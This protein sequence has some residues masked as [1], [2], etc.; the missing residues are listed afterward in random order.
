MFH[1]LHF[2]HFSHFSLIL[3]KSCCPAF[4]SPRLYTNKNKLEKCFRKKLQIY[5][6]KR[7][8]TGQSSLNCINHTIQSSFP[9]MFLLRLKKCV[10]SSYDWYTRISSERMPNPQLSLSWLWGLHIQ[11][12]K[13]VWI[14]LRSV[15]ISKSS[16]E[17]FLP[18]VE[19][20]CILD[21]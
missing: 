2:N 7:F 18:R 6:K 12:Y 5:V 10:S 19:K 15:K 21:T 17:L 13:A 20:E 14:I 1:H 8:H 16:L 3:L 11:V 9:F 4:P